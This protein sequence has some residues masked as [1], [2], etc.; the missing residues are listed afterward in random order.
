[1]LSEQL[2]TTRT[3]AT[4]EEVTTKTDAE[5]VLEWIS[6]PGEVTLH[7]H[8]NVDADAAFSA[9]LMLVVREDAT[10]K[11]LPADTR[12]DGRGLLAV[13]MMNGE[14]AVKGIDEGSAF[15]QLVSILS[16][17]RVVPHRLFKRFAEQLN[18]TDSGKTC[19]DR[20]A[21]AGI[22]KSWKYAGLDDTEMV[23]RAGEILGG[24]MEGMKANVSMRRKSA[25]MPIKDGIALNLT[26]GG[27]SRRTLAERGA[28]LVINHHE[29]TGQS[30]V[31]TSLG[32]RAGLDLNR[33]S[34]GLPEKWFI[35]PSGFMACYGSRKCRK[36][37]NESGI[38]LEKLCKCVHD[39]LTES[40]GHTPQEATP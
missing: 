20:V 26:G 35:H 40:L 29:G 33:M 12:V 8:T 34:E 22:V 10:L 31:L 4:N 39:W 14:S 28:Y 18:L 15:G 6:H 19:N 2:P 3:T 27:L 25:N 21:L 23:S 38:P 7:T 24:M 9:A 30:V 17:A 36:D 11:L 32:S 5:K 37:P 13:D 1:M 16:D